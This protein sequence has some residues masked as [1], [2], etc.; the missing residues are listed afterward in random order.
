M[1]SIAFCA[2][3]VPLIWAALAAKMRRAMA[4]LRSLAWSA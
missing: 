4:L 3:V 2:G 1:T